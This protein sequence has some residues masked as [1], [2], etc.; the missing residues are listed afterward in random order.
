MS[1]YSFDTVNRHVILVIIN[2]MQHMSSHSANPRNL[3]QLIL[4]AEFITTHK[5][6]PLLLWDSGY[7]TAERRR[8]FL[9]LTL[10]DTLKNADHLIIDGTFKSAP[11]LMTQMVGIH[12]LFDQSWHM[13][14]GFVL[15]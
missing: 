12:G 15:L 2:I 6:D 1:I 7:N 5:G 10:T 4:P 3:Q 11:Q 13:P 9:T 8:S 14:L